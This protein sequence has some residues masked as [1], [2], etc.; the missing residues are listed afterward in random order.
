MKYFLI[1][2][3]ER[4]LSAPVVKHIPTE[5]IPTIQLRDKAYHLFPEIMTV[6]IYEGS[7]VDFI[8]MLSAPFLLVSELCFGVIKMY[9]PY[10]RSKK[11]VLMNKDTNKVYHLPLI[12]RISCLT[13]NSKL[14]IDKSHIEYAELD[15]EKVKQHGIFYIGDSSSNYIVIRLDMLESMFKRGAKGFGIKEIDVRGL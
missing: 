9:N 10:T 6:P 5:I 13:E 11:M 15:Y 3:D 7:D 4:Y 8:D 12:P 1:Q 14:N 2:K